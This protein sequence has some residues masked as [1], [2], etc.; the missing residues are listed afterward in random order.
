MLTTTLLV[1]TATTTVIL[2]FWALGAR[3]DITKQDLRYAAMLYRSGPEVFFSHGYPLRGHVLLFTR[4]TSVSR[5][6]LF[7]FAK[8]QSFS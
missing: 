1:L 4:P 8:H 3:D 7:S 5:S 6:T 2:Q